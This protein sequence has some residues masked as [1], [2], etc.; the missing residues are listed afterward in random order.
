MQNEQI[1]NTVSDSKVIVNHQLHKITS[2]GAELRK[3][4][5][6][7]S[8]SRMTEWGIS[9]WHVAQDQEE[10]MARGEGVGMG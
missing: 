10:D 1:S 7:S 8:F 4:S 9:A 2:D 6:L 5:S 3:L